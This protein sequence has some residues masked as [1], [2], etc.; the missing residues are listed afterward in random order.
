MFFRAHEMR[1][2]IR[3]SIA[4]QFNE[5][6]NVLIKGLIPQHLIRE[7]RDFLPAHAAKTFKPGYKMK[8]TDNLFSNIAEPEF[9]LPIARALKLSGV[10]DILLGPVSFL[11]LPTSGRAV[12]PNHP[13]GLGPV[14]Q[15]GGRLTDMGD[16]VTAWVPLVDIDE[17]CGGLG[18]YPSLGLPNGP[19]PEG[20]HGIDVG[21]G[22]PI[23]VHMSAGDVLIFHKWMPHG[24][25]PN[26]SNRVRYSMDMRFYSSCNEQF[27][28]GAIDL[29]TWEFI[30]ANRSSA[31]HQSM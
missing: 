19:I 6:R 28:K 23:P 14:H 5:N 1:D 7:M 22:V 15:D 12:H 9:F 13:E 31:A 29:Q 21:S 8:H 30:P 24:S 16:F 2:E 4:D 10:L 11:R 3:R 25:M 18:F 27:K 26:T 17:E 20:S